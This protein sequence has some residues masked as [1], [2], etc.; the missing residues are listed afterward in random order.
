MM[1]IPLIGTNLLPIK[2]SVLCSMRVLKPALDRFSVACSVICIHHVSLSNIFCC[3][4]QHG[5][6]R[7]LF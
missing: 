4:L 2:F 7:Q 5:C 6:F 1:I 3:F